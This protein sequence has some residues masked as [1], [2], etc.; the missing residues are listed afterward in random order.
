MARITT[1]QTTKVSIMN[2]HKLL[3]AR[4]SQIRASD[5]AHN[6]GT[7]RVKNYSTSHVDPLT[8]RSS[9]HFI[10]AVFCD[11][12][13]CSSTDLSYVSPVTDLITPRATGYSGYLIFASIYWIP[14]LGSKAS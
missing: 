3:R 2:P 8:S 13:I 4:R 10:F 6:S 14:E 12:M 5:R 7:K 1:E 9:M 11:A